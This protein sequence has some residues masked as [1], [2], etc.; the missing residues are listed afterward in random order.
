MYILVRAQGA[1]F[2]VWCG[3]DAFE[4]LFKNVRFYIPT[5]TPYRN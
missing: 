4:L 1:A 2:F 3:S 5:H